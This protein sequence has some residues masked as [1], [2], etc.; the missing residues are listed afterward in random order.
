MKHLPFGASGANPPAPITAE[1]TTHGTVARADTMAT[2]VDPDPRTRARRLDEAWGIIRDLSA[3][4]AELRR[5]CNIVI[6][7]CKDPRRD[8]ARDILALLEDTE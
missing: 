7:L 1:N 8:T 5:A 3:T 2:P 6:G 4:D